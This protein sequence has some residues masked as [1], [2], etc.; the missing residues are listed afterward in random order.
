MKRFED[1]IHD[2]ATVR[3]QKIEAAL[4]QVYCGDDSPYS[5]DQRVELFRDNMP[6]ERDMEHHTASVL[7]NHVGVN[8]PHLISLVVDSYPNYGY[9]CLVHGVLT[10]IVVRRL[11]GIY[12][13]YHTDMARVAVL[14]ALFHDS[15][16]THGALS[17]SENILRA[18]RYVHNVVAL[19]GDRLGYPKYTA[20]YVSN[21]LE[22]TEWTAGAFPH[23]IPPSAIVPLD[24]RATLDAQLAMATRI[25]AEADLMMSATP[26][27][28]ALGSMIALDM[29]AANG[30]DANLDIEQFCRSQIYFI[31]RT[32]LSRLRLGETR[33][34]AMAVAAMH[35]AVMDMHS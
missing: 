3:A 35:R 28:P 30:N 20:Q 8:D 11:C 6:T 23:D 15:F 27:W 34:A 5:R 22:I 33:E 13:P 2:L 1:A 10:A 9:H 21:M 16:H 31:E 4:M 29:S 25:V 32:C 7:A 17:D 12:L 26:L 24:H 14:A 19:H 18:Q